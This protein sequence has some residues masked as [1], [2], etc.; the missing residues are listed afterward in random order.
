M[1][2]LNLPSPIENGWQLENGVLVPEYTVLGDVPE[3]VIELVSCRCRKGCKTNLCACRKVKLVCTDACGCDDNDDCENK[4]EIY[5]T[6]DDDSDD[7]N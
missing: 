3:R 1:P 6:D 7:S 2:V 4:E 5:L